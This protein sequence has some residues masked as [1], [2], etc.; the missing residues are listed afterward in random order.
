MIASVVARNP[1]PRLNPFRGGSTAMPY[2]PG[3]QARYLVAKMAESEKSVVDALSTLT[4]QML[5]LEKKVDSHGTDLRKVAKVDLAMQS[6]S[7]VQ[8]EQVNVAKPLKQH[9][10]G[11]ST[12][13]AD[14]R[15]LGPSSGTPATSSTGP[16]ISHHHLHHQAIS[17]A[18]IR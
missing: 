14:S 10:G 18:I 12:P 4:E 5:S 15:V 6:I 1:L 9:M 16:I 2:K 17:Y 13:P 11:A 3:P 7:L 8:Q